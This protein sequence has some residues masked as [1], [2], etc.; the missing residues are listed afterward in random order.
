MR[1]RWRVR[2]RE[3]NRDRETENGWKGINFL[4][5]LRSAGTQTAPSV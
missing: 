4:L 1:K 2:E 5:L 3:S